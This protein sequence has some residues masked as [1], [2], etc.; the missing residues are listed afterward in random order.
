MKKAAIYFIFTAAALFAADKQTFTG[1]IS[2]DMCG[3]NH[4]MMNVKPDS[5]CVTDCGKMG[6][7]YILLAGANVYQLSDQKA[8]E[9]FP[10]K[11]VTVTGTLDGK[12]INVDSIAPAK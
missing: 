11:K 10:A 8:A 4:K 2:D 7:K 1:V 3:S 12:T 6:S 5:K 9:K